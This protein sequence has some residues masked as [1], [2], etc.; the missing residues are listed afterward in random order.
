MVSPKERSY[1]G[2]VLFVIYIND[3]LD[4]LSSDGLMF[5]DDTK[6]FRQ[7]S[8]LEDALHLQDDLKKMEKWSDTWLLKFNAEKCHVL[9]LGKFEDIVHAHQYIICSNEL[10]HVLSEKD[11]GVTIDEELKFE[12]HIM[13]K[14]Q[15]AN[16][17]V[18]Q[19]RRSFSFL[20]AETF[21]RIYVASSP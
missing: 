15:I 6:I 1:V 11:P 14:V 5:A 10:E 8:S 3:L 19:I 2:P 17:I 13:R 9:T 21:R 16:D 4:D 12:E 18:G 7:I 20:D